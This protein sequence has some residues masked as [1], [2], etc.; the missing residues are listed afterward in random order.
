MQQNTKDGRTSAVY[1]VGLQ[2]DT[3][4]VTV[5]VTAANE[6]EAA[7]RACGIEGAPYPHAVYEVEAT[8]RRYR[9]FT[10]PGHSWLEVPRTEVVA[11]GASITPYSYYDPTTDMAYLEEDCDTWAFLKAT[12][13][14]WH[15]LPVVEVDSSMPRS[16]DTY[17]AAAFAGGCHST[18]QGVAQ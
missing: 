6:V 14:D 3:G 16:L 12:G 11:S 18:G 10:D 7:R 4:P 9:L 13:Q 17:D 5:T 2:S 15:S 8:G 1:Y